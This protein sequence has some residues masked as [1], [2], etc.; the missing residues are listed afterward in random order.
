VKREL[1]A[2]LII[3]SG[4]ILLVENVKHG[5]VR[6]E[7]PGGKVHEGEVREESVRRE[8]FEETGLK[9][10][11]LKP[12]GAYETSSPEGAFIVHMYLCGEA[13]GEPGVMEPD[14]ISKV[15]WYGVEELV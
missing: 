10:G 2:A 5:G 9:V 11:A 1:V 15:G 3:R 4:R 13:E 14:K 12:F 8:V 7:P 6:M